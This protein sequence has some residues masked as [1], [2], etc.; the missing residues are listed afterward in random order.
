[1]HA[2]RY[3]HTAP[4]IEKPSLNN[5]RARRLGST[6]LG[7]SAGPQSP[8]RLWRQRAKC[9]PNTVVLSEYHSS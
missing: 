8:Q 4:H 3:Y 2:E 1:M 5:K 9:A 6:L 7:A